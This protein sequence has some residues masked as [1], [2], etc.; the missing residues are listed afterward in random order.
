MYLKYPT[1]RPQTQVIY[2]YTINFSLKTHPTK[3]NFNG[4]EFSYIYDVKYV[5]NASNID[6]NM[7]RKISY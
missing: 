2:T 4:K 3:N 7:Q 1:P 5:I 6:G